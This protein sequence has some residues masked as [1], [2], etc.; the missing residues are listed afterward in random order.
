[1]YDIYYIMCLNDETNRNRSNPC[2]PEQL[3]G[4]ILVI[5]VV[6]S[7]NEG[8]RSVLVTNSYVINA[9]LTHSDVTRRR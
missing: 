1:M 2:F 8:H 6:D 4:S 9:V 7:I 3:L 5:K